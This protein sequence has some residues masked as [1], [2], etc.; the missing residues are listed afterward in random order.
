MNADMNAKKPQLNPLLKLVLDLG[1]LVLFFLANSRPALFLPLVAPILPADVASGER[2]GIF[3]ATAVFMAAVVIALAISYALTRHLPIMPL[4]TAVVVLVFGSLTLVLHDE[5][6]IKLKPTIIYLLFGGVLLGG[7]A[8]GK[9]VLGV[10]F[11]S[12]FHLTEEGWRRLTL[13]W[14][15]FFFALAILN[16]IVWRTQSTDFWVNFKVFG[17]VPL[18]FLFAAAQYP[19]LTKYEAPEPKK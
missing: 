10:V 6:F 8:L 5:L 12:V 7:L 3:V 17:V 15:L 4:V 2:V 19:L 18:T 1:P 16:E 11:D 14:A 13:R 9:P